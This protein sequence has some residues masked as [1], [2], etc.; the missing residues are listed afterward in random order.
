MS[1]RSQAPKAGDVTLLARILAITIAPALSVGGSAPAAPIP[2]EP[3]ARALH[4]WHD[5][6]DVDTPEIRFLDVVEQPCDMAG[7]DGCVLDPR[8]LD[9]LPCYVQLSPAGD[10]DWK[11]IAHEIGHCLRLQDPGLARVGAIYPRRSIM[12]YRY[13]W[14]DGE[15]DPT[16]ERV[17]IDRQHRATGPS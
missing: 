13:V 16:V 8:T 11:V 7:A 1:R 17:A 2:T 14:H 4:Y 5:L 3:H 10:R 15:P 6:A 12:N 9:K